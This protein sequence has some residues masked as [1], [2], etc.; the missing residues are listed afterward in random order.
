MA[1]FRLE[2]NQLYWQRG[3]E[4]LLIQPWGDNG[5]RVRVTR[6][7]QLELT[8]NW[9]LLP[10]GEH[11]AQIA[12]V[13]T[14]P[15][16]HKQ[17]A[18]AGGPGEDAPLVP[19]EN[20]AY[21]RNGKV[22]AFIDRHG[23]LFFYNEKGEELTRE[24][25]RNR[26]D[27]SEYSVPLAM[28]GRWLHPG[29]GRDDYRCAMSFEAYE[30]EKIYGMGQYQEDSL[31][32]KGMKLELV[33]RNSQIS[34]PFMVSSRGYGLLWNN[35][36]V[37]QVTFARNVTKWEAR[38]T[39]QIDFWITAG[40][41]PDEIE[42]NYASATGTVPMMRDDLMGFWQ[43]KLRYRTQEEL[44]S[45]VREHKRRGLPM[46][47]IVVDFFHWTKQGDWKFDPVDW[48]DPEGMVDELKRYGVNLV[49]S[50]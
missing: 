34:C 30:D 22:A 12:M 16:N 50:V 44:L 35:P 18:A 40:G 38:S 48:P 32:L 31:N 20:A 3:E 28:Q 9:A 13:K 7:A 10:A 36:A 26:S 2:N 46:D 19:E 15:K 11:T 17:M 23:Y 8:E 5:L 49:V 4:K 45:V 21:I 37:G 27:L 39:R 24:Y 42:R 1:I 29:V 14:A 25:V 41:T 33:Q 47:A 6:A 43:C